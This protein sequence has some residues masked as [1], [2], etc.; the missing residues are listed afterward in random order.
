MRECTLGAGSGVE[1]FL[2]VFGL[3]VIV[4]VVADFDFGLVLDQGKGRV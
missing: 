1:G 3:L 2:A 4:Q